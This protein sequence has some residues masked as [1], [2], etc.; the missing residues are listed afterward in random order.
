ML[1]EQA[2]QGNQ[3]AFEILTHRYSPS[4]FTFVR[5]HS[6]DHETAE[7]IVQSVFLQL[8]LSL[9]QHHQHLSFRRTTHP[10]RAWLLCVAL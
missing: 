8:Y 2:F 3:K 7:D 4:L 5:K 6:A 10:L 1:I 9:P